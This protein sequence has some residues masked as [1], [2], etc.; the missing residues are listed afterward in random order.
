MKYWN[1]LGIAVLVLLI[2]SCVSVALGQAPRDDAAV[3]KVAADSMEA[4]R[5]SD[6]QKFASFM[7]PEALREFQE[8]LGSALRAVEPD[9]GE[10]KQVLK[11]FGNPK[12][13][14]TLLD[15]PPDQ[16]FMRFLQGVMKSAPQ[17]RRI[18]SGTDFQMIGT[19]YEK[20]GTAHV[21]Y[22]G[23]MKV[24]DAGFSK[25]D[26]ISLKPDGDTWRL[27]LTGDF[28]AMGESLRKALKK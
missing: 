11:L 1:W 23:K 7:H 28:K 14:R 8:T 2:L 19:V 16:F 13:V 18:L 5:K 10:W 9:S 12:D 22:R 27:L 21:V 26:V 15:L 17:V 6:W 24:E 4:V 3:L 20:D 25:V